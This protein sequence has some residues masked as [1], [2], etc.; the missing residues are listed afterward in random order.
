MRTATILVDCRE[1][2]AQ[3]SHR[4][5]SM[6]DVDRRTSP[7]P[8]LY[9]AGERLGWVFQDRNLYR[10]R[11]VEPTP[12]MGVVPSELLTRF[13]SAKANLVPRMLKVGT[14]ALVVTLL[15]GCCA[16]SANSG[17]LGFI[18]FLALAGGIAGVAGIGMAYNNAKGALEQAQRDVQNGYRNA[19]ANW[20]AR[21]Q[22]FERAEQVRV[23]QMFEWGAAT[24]APGTRRVD[25]IGGSIWGGEALLTVFGGLLLRTPR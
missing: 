25:I 1:M 19:T 17:A 21:T 5:I 23:D 12:V 4:W 16:G 3:P 22:R 18:A 14:A 7:L 9:A 8:A 13:N 6:T 20:E 24:P 2:E 15:F 10:M 11:F